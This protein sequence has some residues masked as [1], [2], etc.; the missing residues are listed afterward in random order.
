MY[1]R[2][3]SQE[4][5]IVVCLCVTESENLGVCM[6]GTHLRG[7]CARWESVFLE[8]QLPLL[9][10]QLTRLGERLPQSS[11]VPSAAACL[12]IQTLQA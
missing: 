11:S 3:Y 10:S 1:V 4:G 8:S 7:V 2:A 6:C 9:L 12:H 5:K